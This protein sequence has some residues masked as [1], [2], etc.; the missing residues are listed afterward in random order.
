MKKVKF[1]LEM[2][3]K[4]TLKLRLKIMLISDDLFK[5]FSQTLGFWG[6]GVERYTFGFQSQI[7]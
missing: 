1:T 3:H 5:I 4:I 6:F 2:E 7:N